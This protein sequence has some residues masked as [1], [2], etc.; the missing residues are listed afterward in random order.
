MHYNEAPSLLHSQVHLVLLILK[1]SL[2]LLPAFR[3]RL[4]IRKAHTHAE[5]AANNV[6]KGSARSD[7]ICRRNLWSL[8]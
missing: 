3:L 2:S 5:S 4:S 7:V 1:G 6:I 8:V